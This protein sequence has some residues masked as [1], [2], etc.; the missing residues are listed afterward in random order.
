MCL[1]FFFLDLQKETLEGHE[2]TW[3]SLG[4]MEIVEKRG[5][6]EAFCWIPYISLIH[7]KIVPHQK[8]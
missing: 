1:H 7:D 4:G 5:K 6:G 3:F 2:T 8:D